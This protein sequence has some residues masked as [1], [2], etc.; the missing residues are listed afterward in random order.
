MKEGVTKE[1]LVKSLA[2]TLKLTREGVI[3]LE[4]KDEDTVVIHYRCGHKKEVNIRLNSGL[5]IIWDVA[6][7][8]T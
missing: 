2:E 6:R 5:A 3:D 8:V 4:I 7:N 1:Q